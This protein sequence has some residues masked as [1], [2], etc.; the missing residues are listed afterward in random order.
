MKLNTL[1]LLFCAC[2][3]AT[4]IALLSTSPAKTQAKPQTAASV[5]ENVAPEGMPSRP[6]PG[7]LQLSDG[8]ESRILEPDLATQLLRD[9]ETQGLFLDPSMTLGNLFICT[10]KNK[11]LLVTADHVA[12][13]YKEQGELVWNRSLGGTEVAA[14][15]LGGRE[16]MDTLSFELFHPAADFIV[17]EPGVIHGYSVR[18]DSMSSVTIFV[19]GKPRLISQPAELA[20]FLAELAP[21]SAISK[22][23][24]TTAPNVPIIEMEVSEFD[25]EQ[26]PTLSG[27]FLWQRAQPTGVFVARRPDTSNPEH[28]RFF[29]IIEPLVLALENMPH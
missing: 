15:I 2:G 11:S 9:P 21:D 16:T 1:L 20:K 26:L 5:P 22:R 29:A 19:R 27:S 10:H 6:P 4:A 24:D 13:D 3:V 23:L 18:G 14:S 25:Y 12:R 8:K 7:F 28:P 17:G